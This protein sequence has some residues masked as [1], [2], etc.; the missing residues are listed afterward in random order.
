MTDKHEEIAHAIEKEMASRGRAVLNRNAVSALFGAFSDPVGAL[1][2]LFLG[3]QEALDAENMRLQIEIILQ[4]LCSIDDALSKAREDAKRGGVTIAGEF[5][6]A[7]DGGE[8]AYAIHIEDNSVPVEFTM[9][10]RA[11]VRA[12]NVR[13]AAALK[14]GGGNTGEK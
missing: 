9:G 2:K 11:V 7:I 6:L 5:E 1:G 3:R 8:R 12:Q 10:T 14:I 13:E 4:M